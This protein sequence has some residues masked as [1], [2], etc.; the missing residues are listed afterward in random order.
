MTVFHSKASTTFRFMVAGVKLF[1]IA[2]WRLS[3][4][5]LRVLLLQHG[6]DHTNYFSN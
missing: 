1:T 3:T 4:Q 2:N 5:T 6:D